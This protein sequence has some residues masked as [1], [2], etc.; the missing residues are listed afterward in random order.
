[1]CLNIWRSFEG[2]G[3]EWTGF[4]SCVFSYVMGI[5][6]V[7]NSTLRNDGFRSSLKVQTPHTPSSITHRQKIT[8]KQKFY[9][10]EKKRPY[11][12][13]NQT[14]AKISI[15]FK[16][17]AMKLMSTTIL[18][19]IIYQSQGLRNTPQH[20]KLGFGMILIIENCQDTISRGQ[21]C[22]GVPAQYV[23]YN[24]ILWYLSKTIY[25]S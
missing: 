10:K 6:K 3:K 14:S 21:G 22:D 15:K 18:S 4:I 5:R 11:L 17:K 24:L 23:P 25:L 16:H 13:Q 9:W 19:Q 8:R 20:K 12:P 7:I 1:M 2:R